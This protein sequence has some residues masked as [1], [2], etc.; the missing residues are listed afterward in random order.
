MSWRAGWEAKIMIKSVTGTAVATALNCHRYRVKDSTAKLD[1]SNFN[2]F[3]SGAIPS[4]YDAEI[5]FEFATFD[6]GGAV[7]PAST[8]FAAARALGAAAAA[9][10]APAFSQTSAN[11]FLPDPSNPTVRVRAGH[12]IGIQI[13]LASAVPAFTAENAIYD[14]PCAL[15]TDC[16]VAGEVRGQQAM[17]FTAC[18]VFGF[19][20]P[21]GYALGTGMPPPGT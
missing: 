2:A 8:A 1:V 13:W 15:I 16:E 5:T 7:D 21:G 17:T 4:I 3:F 6:D 10:P 11:P 9:V 20:E 18:N 12:F 14:F 19:T